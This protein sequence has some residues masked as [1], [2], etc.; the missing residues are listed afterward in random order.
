MRIQFQSIDGVA[1]IV[2]EP[3]RDERGW[4]GRVYDLEE[5]ARSGLVTHFPQRSIAHNDR[6]GTIRGMHFTLPPEPEVKMI[7][8]LSGAIYDVAVDVRPASPTFGCWMGRTLTGGSH[9]A[10]YVPAGVAHG[11]QTLEERTD[12]MYDIS[13]TYVPDRARNFRYDDPRV[14]IRWPLPVRSISTRD[15]DAPSFAEVV[16]LREIEAFASMLP[17]P[18][19]RIQ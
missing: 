17:G 19:S 7:T 4:F 18:Q 12:V 10:L 2:P 11:Y 3:V 1:L 15:A 6:S 8:C 5:F 13:T 9:E 16:G 14:A